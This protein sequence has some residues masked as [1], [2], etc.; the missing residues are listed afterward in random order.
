MK[1]YIFN[2]SV[3]II[4]LVVFGCSASREAEK[5]ELDKKAVISDISSEKYKTRNSALSRLNSYG[6]KHPLSTEFVDVLIIQLNRE[7]DWR[8]KV[9]IVSALGKA[10]DKTSVLPTLIHCLS[11]RDDESSGSGMV[12]LIASLIL[13]QIGNSSAVAPMRDWVEY[14]KNNPYK[15]DDKDG[16]K[17]YSAGMLE[18]SVKYLKILGKKCVEQGQT[19]NKVLPPNLLPENEPKSEKQE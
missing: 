17:T 18:Q 14:L 15:L 6:D 5:A 12:P 8:I 2:S 19:E 9:K 1:N 11:C 10:E 3:I 13:S 16:G 7:K 4:S